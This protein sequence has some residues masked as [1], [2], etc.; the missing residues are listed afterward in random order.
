MATIN[1]PKGTHDLLGDEARAYTY[2]SGVCSDV[3][4]LYGY[5]PLSTPIFEANELFARGVGGAT[6]IVRKEMY[7]FT[8]KGERLMALRPEGTAGVIRS[9][10]DKKLY[11]TNPLPLRYYYN[12]PMFRYERPQ[13]GRY[14][15]FHQFGVENIGGDSIYDDLE[16]ILLALHSLQSLG[17]EK[18][19]TTIN[20]LSSGA[21]RE[22]YKVALKEFYRSHLDHLCADCHVRYEQNPL[23]LL[24]CKVP[25]DAALAKKAPKIAEFLTNQDKEDLDFIISELANYGFE[26]TID[27]SLVRGLDYYSGVIFEFSYV[28]SS[29]KDYGAIGGGGRYDKLISS[30]G[31]PAYEGVGFAFGLE[32]LYHILKEE[33]LLDHITIKDDVY[34]ISSSKTKSEAF[35]LLSELRT[36]GVRGVM[37]FNDKSFK[38]H[39]KLAEA[40][41]AKYALIIGEDELAAN[42]VTFRDLAN[43]SQ[44]SVPSAEIVAHTVHSLGY[45]DHHDHEHCDC[46]HDHEHCECDHDHEHEGCACGHHHHEE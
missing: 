16:V 15:Q 18:V 12:G 29:A 3:A 7:V 32:R 8:D 40:R 19:T 45:H 6:D 24:D 44:I 28:P 4:E 33:G 20:S 36:E 26:A 46:D 39:F 43:Q 17:F 5:D 41:G 30:L 10:I 23:R 38:A 14:R 22:R 21:T 13:L 9:V 2:I 42:T 37:S 31:G 1:S 35:R 34:V 25:E 11:A 27:Y